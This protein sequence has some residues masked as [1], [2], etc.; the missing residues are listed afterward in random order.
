MWA[1][2]VATTRGSVITASTRSAAPLAAR[3]G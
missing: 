2:M 1:R 3:S